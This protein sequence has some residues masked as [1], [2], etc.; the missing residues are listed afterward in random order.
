MVDFSADIA[1]CVAT[2]Q[3]GGVIVYPT[4]T[5]WG[6]GCDA[7]DAAAVDKIFTLKH[8]PAHKSMI[9]LVADMDQL[10]QYT[11]PLKGELLQK[12]QSFDLPTTVV[13]PIAKGLAANALAADGSIGI[14]L[15]NDTFCKEMILASGM[16]LLS[17]SANLSGEPTASFFRE[18]DP[19]LLQGAD[20]VVHYRQ[21]DETIHQPSRI[22]KLGPDGQFEMI[23]P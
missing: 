13:Y 18:I 9:V 23:R 6:I 14:R 7:R 16:P 20:Y 22:L 12:I 4:D 10:Q 1:S 21:A 8:R 15:V 19:L 11:G 3:K 17:T 5:V 2:L